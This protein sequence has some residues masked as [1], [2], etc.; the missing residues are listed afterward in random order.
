MMHEIE[1]SLAMKSFSHSDGKPLPES[2]MH[3][4]GIFE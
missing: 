1:A 3:A 2:V 4:G